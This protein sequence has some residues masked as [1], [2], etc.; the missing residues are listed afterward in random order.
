MMLVWVF[1]VFKNQTSLFIF[2][3]WYIIHK[4]SS[5]ERGFGVL[6]KKQGYINA[7]GEHIR[8]G[9]PNANEDRDYSS[10]LD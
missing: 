6:G 4:V 2:S 5:S 3:S 9:L 1:W 7:Q 8:Y 10:A